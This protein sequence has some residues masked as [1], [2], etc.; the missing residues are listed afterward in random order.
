MSKQQTQVTTL[1]LPVTGEEKSNSSLLLK[2]YLFHWPLFILSAIVFIGIAYFYLSIAHPIYPISA[3]IEFKTPT[4]SSASLTVNQSSTDAQLDPIDKPVIVE[5]EIEVMQSK[6]ILYQVVNQLGVWVTYRQKVGIVSKD[7]YNQTPV[8]FQFVKQPEIINP[9][10]EK[11]KVSIKDRNSF[12][13]SDKSGDEK[14]GKFSTPITTPMGTWQLNPTSTVTNYV[15]SAL[16]LS[17]NDPDLV[18]DG[19]QKDIKVELENKDAPFVNLSVSDNVPQRG[20]DLLN[21]VMALYLQYALEDKNRLSQKTLKFIDY[22]LDSLKSEL[23]DIE[24]R[25]ET[26][27]GSHHITW[28]VDT[29][30]VSYQG[31]RLQNINNLNAVNVQLGVLESLEKYAASVENTDAPPVSSTSLGDADLSALYQKLSDLQVEHAKLAGTLPETNPQITDV[32][33]QIRLLKSSFKAKLATLKAALVAQKQELQSIV[34]GVQ[35]FLNTVPTMDKEL[36]ELKRVQQSKDIIYKFLLEK[37][38]QVGLRYASSVSDSEIVDDAHAGKIK[39]PIP[40]VVYLLGIILGFAAAAGL[41]YLRESLNDL[42]VSRKQIE[43][44]TGV[45]ILGE[46]AYQ[47]TDKQIV[48][49]EGRSKFTIGEQFR[50]LRTNLYH[51]HGTNDAGRVTLFTSSVS[52]EGKSFVSSNLAVTLAYASRKVVILE[53]DLRKPKISVNFGLSS[54]H[55]GISNYLSS[56]ITDLD[57]LIQHSGIENLDVLGCGSILPNPSEL[58]EREQLDELILALKPR[59]DDIIIDSPPIHLVTDALVISRVADASLYVVRQ[60][61]THKYELEFISEINSAERFPKLSIIFN[62]V[63]AG[64]S[65]YGGGY[66]YGYGYGYGGYNKSYN[67][68]AHKEKI[69]FGERIKGVLKRF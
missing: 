49:S 11:L 30:A 32:N 25:I 29:E 31:I 43:D 45:P 26:Y 48:V 66:G 42:I 24:K 67:S 6:K 19:Y 2:K 36:N 33:M 23:D 53:M 12:T 62:G 17:I 37:R 9:D 39:W 59:Y 16:V 38:E 60:G 46:L 69:S 28:S 10:G 47:N 13:Y 61:Y 3:T 1:A 64:A 14:T 40:I 55:K 50:V 41:L 51:L 54:E 8:K 27:K 7:L 57:Q 52:G 65:G 63:K 34:S 44:E 35:S 5:N 56:E 4:A 15:D 68:Y 20:K 58:L 22:R 18:S 21:A